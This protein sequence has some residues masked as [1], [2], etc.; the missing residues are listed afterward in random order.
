MPRQVP[1]YTEDVG[2]VAGEI[3]EVFVPLEEPMIEEFVAR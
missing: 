1:G 3:H 2:E